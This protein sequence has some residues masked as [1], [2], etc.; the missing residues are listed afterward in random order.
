MPSD[1]HWVEFGSSRTPRP[2]PTPPPAPDQPHAEPEPTPPPPPADAVLVPLDQWNRIIGQLGN[3][4]EA[5]QQ[6]AD[7]R[8]RAARAEVENQF[9]KERI[10]DLKDQAASAAPPPDP[11]PDPVEEPEPLPI[12]EP[13]SR[14]LR[15][16]MRVPEW[17][18]RVGRRIRRR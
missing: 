17:T 8:E 9:L 14:T 1:F 13:D 3:I 6:L 10:R 5:G 15:V 12:E 11:E 4:H 16:E 2:T 7:A 18:R